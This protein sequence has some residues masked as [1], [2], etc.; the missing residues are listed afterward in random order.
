MLVLLIS[1]CSAA[2]AEGQ[3]REDIASLGLLRVVKDGEK[4]VRSRLHRREPGLRL[5]PDF[6]TNAKRSAG[7]MLRTVF[8]SMSARVVLMAVAAS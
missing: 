6:A 2:R 1:R 4:L 5:L 8:G 7:V 3:T